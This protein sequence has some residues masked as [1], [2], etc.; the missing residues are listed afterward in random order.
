M[1][2][3]QA[4]DFNEREQSFPQGIAPQ[5]STLSQSQQKPMH[6]HSISPRSDVPSSIKNLNHSFHGTPDLHA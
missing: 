3:E 1:P 2:S 6:A 5:F 4:P